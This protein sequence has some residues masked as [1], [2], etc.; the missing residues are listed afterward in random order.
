MPLG[1]G[2]TFPVWSRSSGIPQAVVSVKLSAIDLLGCLRLWNQMPEYSTVD[3]VGCLR[4]WYHQ[5]SRLAT[6]QKRSEIWQARVFGA[7]MGPEF[8]GLPAEAVG[9]QVWSIL[10][11]LSASDLLGCRRM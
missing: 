7:G 5:K 6:E 1:S 2:V 4:L 11:L 9:L 3:F 8:T 10:N